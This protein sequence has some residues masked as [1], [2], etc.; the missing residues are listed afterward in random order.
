MGGCGCI[1]GSLNH[2]IT[3]CFPFCADKN[4]DFIVAGLPLVWRGIPFDIAVATGRIGPRIG[5]VIYY[6]SITVPEY[7][8]LSTGD[9]LVKTIERHNA[10]DGV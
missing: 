10:L 4:L 9:H 8:P 1:D 6:F 7:A 3:H 2:K 5:F